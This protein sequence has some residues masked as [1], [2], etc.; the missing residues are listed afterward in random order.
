[1]TKQWWFRLKQEGVDGLTEAISVVSVCGQ[2]S[3]VIS[4]DHVDSSLGVHIE[5]MD[6]TVSLQV[7]HGVLT[8]LGIETSL[9]TKIPHC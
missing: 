4:H 9:N 6:I 2:D 1:M 3:G 8:V 5:D 7:Y